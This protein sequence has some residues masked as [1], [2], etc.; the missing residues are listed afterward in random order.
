MATKCCG[1]MLREHNIRY[2]PL[3]K[4]EN[5]EMAVEFPNIE[6]ID[7]ERDCVSFPADLSGKRIVCK[8]SYEALTD[9]FGGSP[10]DPL[11]SFKQNRAAIERIATRLIEGG[12]V[13]DDNVLII[14]SADC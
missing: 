11:S 12:R 7:F 14:Y 8:I 3:P 5:N 2:V 9:H 10:S 4:V 1:L 13:S 6:A